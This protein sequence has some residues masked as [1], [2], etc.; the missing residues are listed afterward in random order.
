MNEEHSARDSMVERDWIFQRLTVRE[1]AA[2]NEE[3]ER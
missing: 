3:G 1:E 2:S